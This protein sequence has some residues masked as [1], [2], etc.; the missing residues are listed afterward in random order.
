MWCGFVNMRVFGFCCGCGSFVWVVCCMFVFSG[1]CV[2]VLCLGVSVRV[3]CGMA[4]VC[5]G[6]WICVWW[7]CVV[8]V[9]VVGV[10]GG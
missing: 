8:G 1:V 4:C 2:G 9:C 3:W 10:C 5:G 7:V 6:V